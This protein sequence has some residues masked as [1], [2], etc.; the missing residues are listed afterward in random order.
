[1]N[2]DENTDLPLPKPMRTHRR[3]P[4]KYFLGMTAPQRFIAA[5]FLLIVVLILGSFFLLLTGKIA[6]PFLFNLP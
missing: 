4:E 2:N 3:K 1:M 6:L 5:L